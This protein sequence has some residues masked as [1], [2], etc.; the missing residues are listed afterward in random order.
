MRTQLRA[1][2]EAAAQPFA[3]VGRVELPDG[4]GA[5]QADN[6]AGEGARGGPEVYV[7][8]AADVVREAVAARQVRRM[9][10]TS[11]ASSCHL[12]VSLRLIVSPGT[13]V[14]YVRLGILV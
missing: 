12:P 7:L 3:M 14:A 5:G 4:V 1:S 6:G 10:A 8:A 2:L 11:F 13:G 9:P